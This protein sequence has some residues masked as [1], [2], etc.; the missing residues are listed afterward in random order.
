MN[1]VA[2]RSRPHRHLR[3]LKT[4]KGS[5]TILINPMINKKMQ[6]R[7]NK[8]PQVIIG[9]GD[10]DFKEKIKEY[11]KEYDELTKKYEQEYDELEDALNEE[12]G[13]EEDDEEEVEMV[14][15]TVVETKLLSENPED[16]KKK[17]KEL[18]LQ[19]IKEKEENA[20]VVIGSL[21]LDKK[22]QQETDEFQLEAMRKARA[23]DI[24]YRDNFVVYLDEK[25]EGDVVKW[26]DKTLTE[27]DW[28]PLSESES[29][30][31]G[32]EELIRSAIKNKKYKGIYDNM[33]EAE[34]DKKI[35]EMKFRSMTKQSGPIFEDGEE[36]VLLAIDDQGN[37]LKIK[38]KDIEKA[39][40]RQELD[41][42]KSDLKKLG[43]ESTL[44]LTPEQITK[45]GANLQ[46][47]KETTQ[48]ERWNNIPVIKNV[49][50]SKEVQRMTQKS[51]DKYLEN[52]GKKQLMGAPVFGEG[53][54]EE[55]ADWDTVYSRYKLG[56][57]AQKE[58]KEKV[59]EFMKKTNQLAKT[60]QVVDAALREK[61]THLTPS[62]IL[63]SKNMLRQAEKQIK[64]GDKVTKTKVKDAKKYFD[65]VSKDH[66]KLVEL[67]STD[68]KNRYTKALDILH[69]QA[70][71]GKRKSLKQKIE[72]AIE[73]NKKIPNNSEVMYSLEA[74]KD[75]VEEAEKRVMPVAVEKTKLKYQDSLVKGIT[76]TLGGRKPVPDKVFIP[77]VAKDLDRAI[78]V[79][80]SR[81]KELNKS[82]KGISTKQIKKT[83]GKNLI[84]NL[85]IK[86]TLP[87]NI[88]KGKS[89]L[90]LKELNN[91]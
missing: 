87:D 58:V 5:K 37:A 59:D 41:F 10:I 21:E 19:A 70:I 86:K 52:S 14:P 77:K 66:L 90:T 88:E 74:M 73:K 72:G 29:K 57:G 25:D 27:K 56:E 49:L 45:F 53:T 8:S 67:F 16:V 48:E 78:D 17:R 60:E 30:R 39:R 47:F 91:F 40:V 50:K 71:D 55:V 42:I 38:A 43:A 76:D 75:F 69:P 18:A 4:K 68:K 1:K 6:I 89:S 26:G 63:I 33:S 12:Y 84:D 36:T 44:D 35:E 65:N 54:I 2:K 28:M 85:F 79:V 15:A 11:G 23:K 9:P 62:Q 51:Y 46:Q 83:V 82:V 22:K 24:S 3:H 81:Q 32:K 31:L 34:F 20:A 13:E 7:R 64:A 61:S 80:E